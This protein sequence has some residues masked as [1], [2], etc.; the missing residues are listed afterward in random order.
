[1]LKPLT[2]PTSLPV[3]KATMPKFTL[4][5]AVEEEVPLEVWLVEESRHMSNGGIKETHPCQETRPHQKTHPQTSYKETIM[6]EWWVDF[7]LIN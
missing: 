5:G 1:M 4:P 6:S 3:D 7:E 2:P